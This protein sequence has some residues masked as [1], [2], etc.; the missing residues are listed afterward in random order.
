MRSTEC[1]SS[2]VSVLQ[3]LCF[4]ISTELYYICTNL[5]NEHIYRARR[6]NNYALFVEYGV[7]IA[8]HSHSFFSC[9]FKSKTNFPL[10][11]H[12]YKVMDAG[13]LFY[14]VDECAFSSY[15]L[16]DDLNVMSCADFLRQPAGLKAMCHRL[17]QRL[18]HETHPSHKWKL[19]REARKQRNRRHG[20]HQS[21]R[22]SPRHVQL[23]DRHRIL[24]ALTRP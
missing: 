6:Y 20:T 13:A 18:P 11:F 7:Y 19:A 4:S 8:P 21:A 5:K 23:P 9:S 22:R 14:S 2:F 3:L 17:W 15:C 10:D 24:T 1:H 12:F 16:I